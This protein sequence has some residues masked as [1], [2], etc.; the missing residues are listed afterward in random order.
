MPLSRALVASVLLHAALVLA[1]T[2][3]GAA[4]DAAAPSAPESRTAPPL[5]AAAGDTFDV[6][7]VSEAPRQGDRKLTP[8]AAP[9]PSPG[10]PAVAAEP[11]P[12]ARAAPARKARRKPRP[13][14]A[15]LPIAGED[16]PAPG[17][18]DQGDQGSASYG[19]AGLPPGVRHLATAFTQAIAAATN[20]DPLWETLPLGKV[21]TA[22]VV[23]DVD[24]D[25]RVT[26]IED[27]EARQLPAPLERMVARTLL[28]LRAGRFALSRRGSSAGRESFEIEVT[29]SQV[30]P[31]EGDWDNPGDTA[32]I[33]FTPP[34]PGVPGRA[35][36]VHGSGRRFDALVTIEST[37]PR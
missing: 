11:A 4:G 33:G 30:P 27:Q 15:D 18:S 16:A 12:P 21:G 37:K 35:F 26:L 19:A 22:R 8:T 2:W 13:T 6:D 5:A 1:F 20:R 25:G 34:S 9:P 14:P 31:P 28:L 17:A 32:S 7:A 10:E 29:L 23:I 24:D 36:F 3:A